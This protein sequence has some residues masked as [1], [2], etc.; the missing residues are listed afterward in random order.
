MTIDDNPSEENSI[1]VQDTFSTNPN[2]PNINT[3]F[4]A[5]EKTCVENDKITD[6][7]LGNNIDKIDTDITK[8]LF[9]IEQENKR[10]KIFGRFRLAEEEEKR[11]NSLNIEYLDIKSRSAALKN[12]PYRR[13]VNIFR[14]A[15]KFEKHLHMQE[16]KKE[17]DEFVPQIV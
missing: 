5:K 13:S 9:Q 3:S 17:S 12:S 1:V 8:T 4:G 14:Q 10:K 16:E 7:S 11:K 15:K 2:T 6:F